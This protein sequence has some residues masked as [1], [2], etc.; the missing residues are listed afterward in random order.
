MSAGEIITFFLLALKASLFSTG[1]LGNVPSLHS[2]LIPRHMAS[3]TQ[4]AESIAVGQVSPGPNGLW[5]ISLGYLIG[6]FGAALAALCAALLPPLLI[7]LVER[8]YR[9]VQ[10]HPFVEGFV[11]GLSLAVVGV[12][13]VVLFNL[14]KSAGG[15]MGLTGKS[16]LIAGASLA[17]GATR[18]VPIAAIIILAAM[19]GLV[20][21]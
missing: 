12:F 3:K 20:W 6:G 5:V 10:N 17:L 11:R 1:G 14:L 18:R 7:L 13:L 15:T 8:G 16:L 2:D 4:F 9:R 21:R 19:V